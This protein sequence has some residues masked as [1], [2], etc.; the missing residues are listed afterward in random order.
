MCP[1]ELLHGSHI[2]DAVAVISCD[3]VCGV[4]T[5]TVDDYFP[6]APGGTPVYARSHGTELWAMLLEKGYAKVCAWCLVLIDIHWGHHRTTNVTNTTN[7]ETAYLCVWSNFS[8]MCAQLH[9]S[10]QA[11]SM[12]WAYEAMMDMTGSCT[13]V[14]SMIYCVST[15]QL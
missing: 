6:C 3:T 8:A 1:D 11:I 4:Q 2:C 14:L 9:G 12:G 15:S 7:T 10:Y 5:V 13:T